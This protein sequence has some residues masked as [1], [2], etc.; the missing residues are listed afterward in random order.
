MV[1][2]SIAARAAHTATPSTTAL[3]AR[4]RSLLGQRFGIGAD[5]LVGFISR[6]DNLAGEPDLP[7]LRVRA[8]LRAPGTGVPRLGRAF[9]PRPLHPPGPDR[10]RATPGTRRAS[11]RRG[12][13]QR[14]PH[15]PRRAPPPPRPPGAVRDRR[16][17]AYGAQAPRLHVPVR[18]VSR[19][20]GSGAAQRPLAQRRFDAQN[21]WAWSRASAT[22]SPIAM[23]AS[24]RCSP[25]S[26][27]RSAADEIVDARIVRARP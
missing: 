25:H 21:P 23:L 13:R 19:D 26:G 6:P 4:L 7:A 2:S 10:R 17:C 12:R 1:R 8:S 27:V 14:I 20:A 16:A 11:R 5:E 22:R 15:S 18:G 3:E 9:H 24:T